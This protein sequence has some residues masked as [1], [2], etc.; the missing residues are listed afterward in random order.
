MRF[1]SAAYLLAVAVSAVTVRNAH[2]A[3]PAGGSVRGSRTLNNGQGKGI[4]KAGGNNKKVEG[5]YIVKFDDAVSEDELSGQAKAAL[6]R[7]GGA[8]KKKGGISKLIH[9]FMADMTEEQALLLANEPGIDAVYEDAEVH[10]DVIWGLDRVDQANLPLDNSFNPGYTDEGSGAVVYV[11]DTGI[12]TSH[13]EF[14]GRAATGSAYDFFTDGYNGSD[15]NGHGTHCAGTVGGAT[16]GVAPQTKLVGVRVLNCQGSGS[17]SG[18]IAGMDK[19]GA[20]CPSGTSTSGPFLNKRCVA[21]MSL[22][23]GA[24]SPVD[25]AVN[26]LKAKGVVVAVAAGN[27]NANACNYSPARASGALTVGSTTSSDYRSSF[28]NYGTCVDIFAP[29]SSVK[30]AWYQT[31]TQTNTISGTSMATPHVAG[32][33]ALIVGNDPNLSAEDAEAQLEAMASQGVVSSPGSG[34]PNLLLNANIANAPTPVTTTVAATTTT[35]AT[36][37]TAAE[38]TTSA[39]TSSPTTPSPTSPP[40]PNPTGAP[41]V[42][43]CGPLSKEQCIN[44]ARCSWIGQKVK[45]CVDADGGEGPEDPEGPGECGTTGT[46]CNSNGDCCGRCN[47]KGRGAT[48]TCF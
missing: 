33:I 25:D 44:D 40:M 27:S 6:A 19:V 29:G 22:G 48:D 13:V 16:Y 46:P 47:N 41:T 28:S 32:A 12:R 18:V 8:L 9:G 2:A 39:P 30:S 36:T 45:E 24:Y 34:S 10:A 7:S 26:R 1:S 38:P 21:S 43:A 15:C 35:K 31:D 3:D 4:I 20:D 42:F 11:I 23:G 17:F 14:G 37:T 5:S